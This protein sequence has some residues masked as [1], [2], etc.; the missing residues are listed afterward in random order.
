MK[1]RANEDRAQESGATQWRVA[2]S[3]ARAGAKE[4][5]VVCLLLAE[6]LTLSEFNAHQQGATTGSRK[7]S[8]VAPELHCEPKHVHVVA[9]CHP[10]VR[11]SR[12]ILNGF[13]RFMREPAF[14]RPLLGTRSRP[15]AAD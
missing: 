14:G 12:L 9:P 1:Q 8:V 11:D 15:T 13:K 5:A 2:G 6:A 3:R 10:A 4:Q 7:C